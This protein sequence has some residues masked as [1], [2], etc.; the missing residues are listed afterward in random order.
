M[1]SSAPPRPEI[2]AGL[3]GRLVAAQFPQWS[4]LPV[5]PV[6]PSGWDNRTFRLGGDLSVRLPSARRYA[7]AVEKEQRWLPK[8]APHLP[9]PIPAP[10]ALGQPGEG[11][12]WP[13]S[14]CRWLPGETLAVAEAAD[15]VAIARDLGGFL[16]ALQRI[17]ASDGPAAGPH[18][19]FRG[20]PL[21]TYD[22]ETRAAVTALGGMV[23]VAGALAVWDA[24]LASRWERSPV[25]VHGDVAP[26]NL[27][28]G[29]GRLSA[30]IDFGQAC[31]GDPACDLAIA[32]TG[33]DGAAR[34]AFRAAVALDPQTWARARGWALWKALIVLAQAPGANPAGRDGSPQI[35]SSLI[36]EH[37]HGG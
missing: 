7:A 17:E 34:E 2:D 13:W 12:P 5:T 23:D 30:V 33:F 10:V 11:Y 27:L 24:A 15:P 14:I 36:A 16:A 3:V 22:A 32:W 26:G 35:I 29:G 9:L 20:G 21:A 6:E 28:V 4:R 18:S 37:R 1:S 25:W 19:F 31:V 8:L